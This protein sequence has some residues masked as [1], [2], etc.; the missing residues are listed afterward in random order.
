MFIFSRGDSSLPN[1]SSAVIASALVLIS[2]AGLWTE[3]TYDESV[4]LLLARTIAE[5]GLPLRRSYNDFSQFQLFENSPPLILYLAS[6]SQWVFPG[7][8]IP[9]RMIH[10]ALFGFPTYAIVWWAALVRFG[11]WS[12]V[13]S[14][15]LLLTNLSFVRGTSHISLNIALGLFAIIGLLTFHDASQTPYRRRS[16]ALIA[17]LSVALAVWTKYQAVTV[18]AA[19]AIYVLYILVTRGYAG[20]RSTILPLLLVVGSS[21]VAVGVLL[22][23]FW[24]FGG[25]ESFT[26]TFSSN[27]S[28]V[29]PQSMGTIARGVFNT[30]RDSAAHLGAVAL[31]LGVITFCVEDRHRGLVVMLA[32]YVAV[33]I[34]FNLTLFRLPGAGSTYLDSAVPALAL[35]AGPAAVRV[36]ALA[37]T[38]AMRIVLAAAAIAIHLVGAPAYAY[39]RPRLNGSREAAAYIA[40]NSPP[41]AG[42]LA[43]TLAIEF[44]SGRPVRAV[45]STYP[46]ELIL[47]SLEGTSGDD[48]SFVVVRPGVTPRNLEEIQQQ[49]NT[50]LSRH[51]EVASTGATGLAVYRRRNQ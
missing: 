45:P 8:D 15:L 37:D 10:L 1:R 31:L 30:A 21:T 20:F 4:Y 26:Q 42:V 40:A 22:A 19:I 23:Y 18:A 49:W 29:T 46:R 44:Y 35:L 50:L 28:R 13:A 41:T 24:V 12:A 5:C 47:R 25:G 36:A 27:V 43:E 2:M 3:L 48:I 7:H 9:S 39:W 32:S 16:L 33:V 11:A 17:G 51:F 34:G 38:A 14:L 6:I